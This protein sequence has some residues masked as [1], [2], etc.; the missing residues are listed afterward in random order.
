VKPLAYE[1]DS[2]VIKYLS[3]EQLVLLGIGKK[4]GGVG[5]EKG[6]GGNVADEL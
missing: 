6:V 1:G 4:H 5:Y 2:G 3:P